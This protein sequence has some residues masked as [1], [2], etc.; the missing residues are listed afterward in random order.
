[1]AKQILFQ[2]I[3]RKK[4]KNGVDKLANTVK[5]TLGPKGRHVVLDKGFG[6]PEICDDGVTIAKEI[7]LEDK[8]ENLGAEIIKEV[9]E[10]T[11]DV[12]G[13]GTTSAVVLAQ[14]IIAEG[15]KNVEAGANPL[16]LQRGIEKG[17]EKIVEFLKKT[18]KKITTKEEMAQV[19]TIS[20]EDEKLGNLI[21]ETM[22]E[23]GKDGVITI[24][25]SKTFGIQKEIVK[26]LQF[27]RGYVSP[28]MITNAERMEAVYEN[29]RILITDKKISSIQEILPILEKLAQAGKKELVI[30]ADD[31]EGEALATL[32]I[33]KLRGVFNTLAIKAPGF[34]D[35]RKEMLE[36]IA[37]VVGTTVISEEIGKKLENITNDELGEA[38]KVISTKDNTIVIGGWGQENR[39]QN[40]EDRISNIK[41]ELK[42]TESD[43]DKEKLK[44]RLAKLAGGVA[45]I[46]VGA[47]TEVEQK[48]KQ[49]KTEDALNATRA[50]VEEGIVPGGGVALLRAISVLD[51]LKLEGDELTGVNI[52]RKA[53]ES[54]IRQ[55]SQ[56]AGI[57]GA[58][59]VQK[60][61]EGK[62]GFGFNAETMKYE[63]LM[64]TGIVDPTKVVRSALENAASS[65]AMFLTTEAVV[66]EKETEKEKRA[67]SLPE[68]Y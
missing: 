48:A 64:S 44:E 47:A 35:R 19:A 58:V 50:A 26:G 16:A 67:P 8:V 39:P 41:A 27:D 51:E 31:V 12:A 29:P 61:K 32:V 66:A 11:N 30:I 56:N 49:H 68:E 65:A 40:I 45:V 18:S 5:V 17:V 52:L 1:M 20:A 2:E 23:V 38:K 53:L 63:D 6:T 34:G 43:F 22:Q 24:E 36:D 46:K 37:T 28:Y 42:T 59:V 14:A 33:N 25:E 21:A 55:I 57:D 15:L 4:L 9:A 62:D 10:K 3:A 13:D 7:E 54:P 60:V